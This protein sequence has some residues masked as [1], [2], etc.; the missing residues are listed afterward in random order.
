MV[1]VPSSGAASVDGVVTGTRMEAVAAV[2]AV[3]SAEALVAAEASAASAAPA[4]SGAVSELDGEPPPQA[5]TR[6]ALETR[7]AS[8]ETRRCRRG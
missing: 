1:V 2:A 6:K 7:E 8:T 5:A 3:P 4:L